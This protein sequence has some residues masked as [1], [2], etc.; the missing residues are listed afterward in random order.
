MA[1]RW[2]GEGG[3][4]DVL[5]SFSCMGIAMCGRPKFYINTIFS[6]SW[7]L[8]G[9]AQHEVGCVA[10]LTSPWLCRHLHCQRQRPPSLQ[11]QG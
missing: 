4:E 8:H 6:I 9:G 1:V 10:V 5:K 7:C 2:K 3:G 11:D